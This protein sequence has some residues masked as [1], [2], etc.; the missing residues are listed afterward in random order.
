[1]VAL[2]ALV[3]GRAARG[4]DRSP[5]VPPRLT[6]PGPDPLVVGCDGPN[7]VRFY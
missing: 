4:R 3:T 5:A 1:V 2:L 7:P 6:G